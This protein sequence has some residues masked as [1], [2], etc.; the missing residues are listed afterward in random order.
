MPKRYVI[1]KTHFI[2]MITLVA[3]YNLK[4]KLNVSVLHQ[5]EGGIGKSI[6]AAQ[7]PETQEIS[8]GRSPREILRVEGNPR[9]F[10]RLWVL[11]LETRGISRGRSPREIPRVEWCKTH[12][13]GKSRGRRGWISQYLPSLGGAR[14]FS[15]HYQGRID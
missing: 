2:K 15:H 12:G 4:F 1:V 7:F 11:H 8:R 5:D 3:G 6:P 10:P 9:D 13:R 14:T